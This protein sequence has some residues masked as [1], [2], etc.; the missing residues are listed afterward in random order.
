MWAWR[1]SLRSC[2]ARCPMSL[3]CL[4][5]WGGVGGDPPVRSSCLPSTEKTGAR[6]EQKVSLAHS[7][8][9]IASPRLRGRSYT[10]AGIQPSPSRD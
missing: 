10:C 9:S 4:A 2:E 5:W 1:R 8:F 7:F 3:L 6:I